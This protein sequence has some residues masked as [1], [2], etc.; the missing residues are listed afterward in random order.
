MEHARSELTR[1]ILF[2]GNFSVE[3]CIIAKVS[4][5][6]AA[7][8]K[9]APDQIPPLQNCAGIHV[10]ARPFPDY[11]RIRS[12]DIRHRYRYKA[13]YSQGSEPLCPFSSL[14]L[15]EID[16][17][18]CPAQLVQTARARWKRIHCGP[19]Y[20]AEAPHCCTGYKPVLSIVRR[21]KHHKSIRCYLHCLISRR[22]NAP[23]IRKAALHGFTCY[24]QHR[25]LPRQRGKNVK[26]VRRIR[27]VCRPQRLRENL[28]A[29]PS[30]LA[31]H[32]KT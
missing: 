3:L 13:A 20:S 9:R 6:E 4:Y 10:K 5:A 19:K 22:R 17:A 11:F 29:S 31:E 28:F 2:H 24:R 18:P 26:I 15:N 32:Q 30:Y 14:P 7:G 8:A 1:Q 25:D 23:C 27:I 12:T 16:S 21:K